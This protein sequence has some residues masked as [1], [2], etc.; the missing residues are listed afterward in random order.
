MREL[1]QLRGRMMTLR[2]VK[3]VEAVGLPKLAK[4]ILPTAFKCVKKVTMEDA[5]KLEENDPLLK[6]VEE[7]ISNSDDDIF[8]VD[9]ELFE[10]MFVKGSGGL[11]PLDDELF[12]DH[13]VFDGSPQ[14]GS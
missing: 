5:G 4:C 11:S 10:E 1:R 13:S 6:A 12:S 9:S 3:E 2:N 14:A 8:S 7:S